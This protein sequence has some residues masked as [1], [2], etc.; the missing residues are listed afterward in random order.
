MFWLL[1][2]VWRF[3][4]YAKSSICLTHSGTGGGSSSSQ[5]YNLVKSDT[6]LIQTSSQDVF[7]S[8]RTAK[9]QELNDILDWKGHQVEAKPIKPGGT[10]VLLRPCVDCC[11]VGLR[12]LVLL[13]PIIAYHY[14]WDNFTFSKGS[15]QRNKWT[16]N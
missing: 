4:L 7:F 8:S 1:Q 10:K 3:D 13:F 6:Q 5:H 16:D 14:L 15:L 11:I 2:G 9:C 12:K